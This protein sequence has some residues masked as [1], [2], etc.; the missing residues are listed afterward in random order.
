LTATHKDSNAKIYWHID[1]TYVG[2][3]VNFHQ[4]AISP[5]AGK[6]T[7]TVVDNKG[8]RLVQIFTILDTDAKN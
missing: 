2:T 7:L 3:T 4:L 1:E 8:N 6:H 5:S